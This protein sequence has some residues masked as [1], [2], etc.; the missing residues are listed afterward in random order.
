MEQRRPSTYNPNNGRTIDFSESNQYVSTTPKQAP[1]EEERLMTGNK[2]KEGIYQS[3][4][5]QGNPKLVLYSYR[6]VVLTCF[7]I[8]LIA[9][10]MLAGTYIPIT[11]LLVK[12]YGLEKGQTSF[13]NLIFYIMYIPGNLSRTA[14]Q[15]HKTL[16]A[17]E[18]QRYKGRP[19]ARAS[20]L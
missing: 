8:A 20:Y 4:N 17:G 14:T 11:S 1:E 16:R 6:W 5:S 12:A 15:G 3:L 13:L 2:P 9:Q 7:S 18:P 10:G 19:A